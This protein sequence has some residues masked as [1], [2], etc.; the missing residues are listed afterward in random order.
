MFPPRM[1]T[2]TLTDAN[3]VCSRNYDYTE[4]DKFWNDVQRSITLEDGLVK[5][6]LTWPSTLLW[7]RRFEQFS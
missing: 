5:G 2:I 7:D 1:E 4:K 6:N 3:C